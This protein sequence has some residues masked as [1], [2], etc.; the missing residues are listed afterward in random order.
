MKDYHINIVYRE[1]DE[2]YIADIPELRYCSAF[3]EILSESDRTVWG[4]AY[5]MTRW[6]GRL[7]PRSENDRHGHLNDRGN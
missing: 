1:E 7:D 6:G 2:G 3:G 5:R 4:L